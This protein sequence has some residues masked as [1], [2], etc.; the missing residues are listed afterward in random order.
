MAKHSEFERKRRAEEAERV[1]EI[2][3]AWTA[4]IP[5]AVAASFNATVRA[6]KERAPGGPPARHGPRHAAPP[7]SPRPRAQAPEGG[8]RHPKASLL[9]RR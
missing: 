1:K 4:S 7:A 9:V 3:R 2:E 8:R 6:A 5:A